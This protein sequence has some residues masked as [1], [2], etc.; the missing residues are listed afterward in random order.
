MVRLFHQGVVPSLNDAFDKTSSAV[1][2]KASGRPRVAA[3]FVS[4]SCIQHAARYVGE[5]GLPVSLRCEKTSL[6]VVG[7]CANFLGSLNAE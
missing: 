4:V 1:I 2:S 5:F 6:G 7:G 3:D